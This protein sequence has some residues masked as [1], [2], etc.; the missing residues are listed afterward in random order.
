MAQKITIYKK[1]LAQRIKGLCQKKGYTVNFV[2][3][4]AC[5]SPG[6][7][8][9]WGAAG[10]SEDFNVLSKLVT[11]ASILEVSVDELLGLSKTRE[12][13]A[14][15]KD[16]DF[17]SNLAK[18]TMDNRLIWNELDSEKRQSL[19][20][21]RLSD[22][23]R[24]RMIAKIWCAMQGEVSFALVAYCDDLADFSEPLELEMYVLAGHGIAPLPLQTGS[25]EALHVLYTCIQCKYVVQSLSSDAS[26]QDRT[27]NIRVVE[28]PKTVLSQ[29]NTID[30]GGLNMAN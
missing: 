3:A 25:V 22:S 26:E 20:G 17:F 1:D 4:E 10:D 24:G 6:M 28:A 8:S 2:E 9:R 30:F 21:N 16:T 13:L 5:Y 18:A 11:M 12:S 19:F 7:I 23:D 29:D 15:N 14:Q 27:N